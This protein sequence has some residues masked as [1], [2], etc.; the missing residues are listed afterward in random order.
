[1]DQVHPR[2]IP[3]KGKCIERIDGYYLEVVV[4]VYM[5]SKINAL[6]YRIFA[7]PVPGVCY[8]TT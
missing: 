2:I 4:E 5:Q 8:I 6:F 7:A 3:G 1:M